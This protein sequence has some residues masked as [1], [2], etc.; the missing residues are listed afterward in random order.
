MRIYIDRQYIFKEEKSLEPR[1]GFATNAK[2]FGSTGLQRVIPIPLLPSMDSLSRTTTEPPNKPKNY[3]NFGH[4]DEKTFMMPNSVS[5]S[6]VLIRV[7]QRSL[8][9]VFLS[10]N[11][12]R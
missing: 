9:G 2:I 1:D 11:K 12:S 4:I 7:N 5:C 6:C 8:T 3:R 10:E